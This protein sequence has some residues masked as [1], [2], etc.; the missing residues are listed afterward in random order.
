MESTI[1]VFVR[2]RPLFD[3]EVAE[4]GERNSAGRLGI[5][6][7]PQAASLVGG[8]PSLAWSLRDTDTIVDHTDYA[9]SRAFTFNGVLPSTCSN[10]AAFQQCAQPL[11]ASFVGGLSSSLIAYGQTGSGKTHSILGTPSDP[12]MLPRSVQCAWELLE[13]ERAKCSG[14]AF[15]VAVSYLEVYMEEVY[16]LLSGEGSSSSSSSSAGGGG[17]A[18]SAR[19]S[20]RGRSSL[21]ILGDDPVK[22]AVVEGLREVPVASYQE[23]RASSARPAV[24]SAG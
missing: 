21:K 18:T 20:A 17:S 14:A 4:D 6:L 1:S 16:D 5:P 23:V 12:G 19:S 2:S 10:A 22:G 13:A 8:S 9:Q 24:R 7:V 3:S 15:T 11:V